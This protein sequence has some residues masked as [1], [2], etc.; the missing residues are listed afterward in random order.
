MKITEII[1]KFFYIFLDISGSLLGIFLIVFGWWS[2]GGKPAPAFISWIIVGVGIS[3]LFI[4]LSH[5][6]I[7][8]KRGSEYFY[9]T[10]KNQN[11]AKIE[12]I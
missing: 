9:T 3:A 11:N 4:H 6:I 8:K 10:R 5:Y 2:K 12:I 7:A 1:K